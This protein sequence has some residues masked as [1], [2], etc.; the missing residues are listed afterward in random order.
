MIG[1]MAGAPGQPDR[2]SALL[3]ADP[4]RGANKTE[5]KLGGDPVETARPTMRMPDQSLG[6]SG[7]KRGPLIER[8]RRRQRLQER[9]FLR[10]ENDRRWRQTKSSAQ[11]RGNSPDAVT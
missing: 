9:E 4:I 8:N 3:R 7:E 6:D 10:S 1:R 2:G 5:L 11:T